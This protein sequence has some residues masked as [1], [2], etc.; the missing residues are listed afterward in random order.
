[1][2]YFRCGDKIVLRLDPKDE[3]TESIIKLAEKENISAAGVSGIGAT[4]DFTVG[5]FDMK[6]G[7]Y[8]KFFYNGNHEI[9]VLTGNIT[10][11]NGKPYVHL[12]LSA[13]GKGGKVVLIDSDA[14][15]KYTNRLKTKFDCL[16]IFQIEGLRKALHRDNVNAIAITNENLATAITDILR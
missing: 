16:T 12:H 9:N 7:D 3:I 8:E 1:M 15:E 5:V 11:V 10:E 4:D 13:T 14:P 2:E 6:K